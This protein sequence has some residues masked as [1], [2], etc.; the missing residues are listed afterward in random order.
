MMRE[1]S[2]GQGDSEPTGHTHADAAPHEPD[3]AAHAHDGDHEARGHAHSPE[4]ATHEAH[5]H[6]DAH[7]HDDRGHTH[8]SDD[9]GH[10]RD[11]VDDHQHVHHSGPL[12]WLSE[13]FGGHSHGAPTADEA[14]EG[15]AEG[16]RAV[17]VSLI[18][19][20][21]TAVLQLAVVAFS[22]SV[23][24][25]ADTIHNFADALTSIPLW[26]AFIVG[27]RA[28]NRRYTYGYG[29]A[30]DVAGLAIVIVITLSAALAAWESIRKLIA[31][32]PIG[33]LGWVM[34]AA[35]IGFIGNETVAIY[36]IRVGQRIGS[37]ALVADGQHARV[38]GLTSLAVLVGALGV[39][40]GFPIA[41]PLIGLVIT[42]AIV[43]VLR[44]AL[45]EVWWR[46]MDA[47]DPALVT[48]LE[49]AAHV[50]G[51]QAIDDVR[52]RWIGHTLHAEAN[53]QVDGAL[54]TTE[55]HAIA[56]EARHAMFHAAP[57]LRSVT[58]HVDPSEHDG[59]DHHTVTEHHAPSRGA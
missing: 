8:P 21:L 28:A 11:G 46:L 9:H 26:I 52:V 57:W 36:R 4:P 15:S 58:V 51:V 48:K 32:E 40:A 3:D 53:I 39:W 45:R 23:G 25:L 18:A 41:D 7:D 14:L 37:A 43:F 29:R 33:Y 44:D 42:L 49:A 20:F 1:P 16:I 22:G 31:P 34:A 19:M 56:E 30:E 55:G 50:S 13:L 17:K 38:D 47:V 5:S 35:V 2:V 27:R 24:L 59:V 6:A 12:G 10:D 54:S